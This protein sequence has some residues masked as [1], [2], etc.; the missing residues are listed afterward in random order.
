MVGAFFCS[1]QKPFNCV[2]HILLLKLNFRGITDWVNKL[3][4]SYLKNYL[5][6]T[7]I[8]NKPRQYFSKWEPDSDGV[9]QGSILLPL[10]LFN[11]ALLISHSPFWIHLIQIPFA[12]DTSMTIILSDPHDFSYTVNNSIININS[13]FISNLLSLNID[14]TKFLQFLMKNSKLTYQFPIRINILWKLS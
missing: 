7:I 1:L 12:D 13:W 10:L 3:L 11:C 2:Y 5:Q 4:V 9:P 8:D 6:T 14:K